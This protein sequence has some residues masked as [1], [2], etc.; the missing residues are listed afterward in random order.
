M[1][2]LRRTK[3]F[4]ETFNKGNFGEK[5]PLSDWFLETKGLTAT[6]QERAIQFLSNAM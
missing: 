1:S 3:G 2:S 5:L 6:G 4:R